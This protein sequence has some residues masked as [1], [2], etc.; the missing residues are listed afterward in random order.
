[1]HLGRTRS[2][3]Q[4]VGVCCGQDNRE[5]TENDVWF[6]R[7]IMHNRWASVLLGGCVC[8]SV[9]VATSYF[10]FN[11]I[12]LF[13]FS[14]LSFLSPPFCQVLR[15]GLVKGQWDE[16]ED[17]ALMKLATKPFKNWGTLS[18]SMPGEL[19]RSLLALRLGDSYECFP[20]C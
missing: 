1:M 19:W 5:K 15:P 12:I 4:G 20:S 14:S 7:P 9:R 6:R 16:K 11:L 3:V 10:F 8:T 13:H 17:A 2:S 18:N